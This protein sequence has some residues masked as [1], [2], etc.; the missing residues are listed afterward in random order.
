MWLS[1]H[2]KK[3]CLLGGMG[4]LLMKY[5]VYGQKTQ[6]SQ[7]F[8][9]LHHLIL[10]CSWWDRAWPLLALPLLRPAGCWG[11]TCTAD[12]QKGGVQ[13]V[14]LL[15]FFFS[16]ERNKLAC[17]IFVLSVVPQ[18]ERPARGE[19][20]SAQPRVQTQQDPLLHHHDG[21]QPQLLLCG[22]GRLAQRA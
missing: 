5:S 20:S 4:V 1:R 21:L 22:Q 19:G 9:S 8:F 14:L 2:G 15:I 6:T 18:E 11:V 17:L 16:F 13:L 12:M 3:S 10:R 7:P